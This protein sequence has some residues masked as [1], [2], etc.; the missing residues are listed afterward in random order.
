[1]LLPTGAPWRPAC[2]FDYRRRTMARHHTPGLTYCLVCQSSS[3]RETFLVSQ[4]CQ[5]TD[6]LSSQPARVF[7]HRTKY[8]VGQV[9]SRR[10]LSGRL[11]F[12][13]SWAASVSDQIGWSA[14][15]SLVNLKGLV[16]QRSICFGTGPTGDHV[17][18]NM[19][20]L[21]AQLVRTYSEGFSR[22]PNRASK[23]VG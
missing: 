13:I 17:A 5:S 9:P 3:G 11:E 6:N 21:R 1:M 4:C 12:R 22:C 20:E 8:R 2:Q 14:T 18:Q 15:G 19:F 16:S 10:Y 23:R 7:D